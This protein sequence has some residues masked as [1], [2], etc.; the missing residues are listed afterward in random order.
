MMTVGAKLL[1]TSIIQHGLK[2]EIDEGADRGMHLREK[3]QPRRSARRLK[4]TKSIAH[5]ISQTGA[6]PAVKWNR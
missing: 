3:N 5:Q 4:N 2:S 1:I 6:T